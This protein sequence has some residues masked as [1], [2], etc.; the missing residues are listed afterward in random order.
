MDPDLELLERWCAGDQA[1]GGAL[2]ARHFAEVY[3]FF[4]RKVAGEPD[5]LVQE[6]FLA[7]VRRRDEF[8]R[9]SSFRTF[10]FAVARF[11]LYAHWRRR[12][13]GGEAVSFSEVSLADLATTP[14]T[15]IE[16]GQDRELLLAALRTLPLDDQLLLEL[17]YWEGLDGEGLA[18]VFDI[19]PTTSRTRL[20]RARQALRERMEAL[21]E[22]TAGVE[23]LD[24]WVRAAGDRGERQR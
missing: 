24:A 14:R 17:H 22:A 18:E 7:C 8:R 23:D 13:R 15:R 1:A 9:Q 20:F 10:V 11:E 21:A 16:R 12:A 3:R 4:E 19:A 6:T 2:F 5:E